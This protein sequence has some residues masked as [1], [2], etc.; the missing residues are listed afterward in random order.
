MVMREK[1]RKLGHDLYCHRDIANNAK[2]T[3][4]LTVRQAI[5][6]F[7][8][9]QKNAVILWFLR[10][11]PF[12]EDVRGHSQDEYLECKGV[13]VTDTA[14]G[15]AAWRCLHDGVERWLISLTPSNWEYSP[16]PV[17]WVIG[18][19][20]R[21]SVSIKNYWE[22]LSFA[23]ALRTAPTQ[24]TSWTHLEQLAVARCSELTFAANA[25]TPLNGHPFVSSAADRVLFLLKKLHQYK[26]SFDADGKLTP[27][28]HEIYQNFFTGRARFSDSS[29]S[30][31]HEFK[32]E[33]TF[34]HPA[35]PGKTI[36]CPWH[37][38]VQTPPYRIHFSW[39]ARAAEPLYIVY[40]G[41]KITKR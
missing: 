36:F 25:F 14:V 18:V 41:P 10:Q 37:G 20:D 6:S 40:V 33:M 13:V 29:D 12:W 34:A 23:T 2:A 17:D 8:R 15:E 7:T 11:G 21:R 38:K 19:D 31:K 9:E 3:Q 4:E 16:I 35:S 22:I 27:D 24:L 28:G 32:T 5:Q 26:S 1:A 39:P 30:E